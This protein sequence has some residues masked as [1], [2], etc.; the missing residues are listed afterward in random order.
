[1]TQTPLNLKTIH[2]NSS[3]LE[4][5]KKTTTWFLVLQLRH[6]I[7]WLPTLVPEGLEL[8]LPNPSHSVI[9]HS[10]LREKQKQ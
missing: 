1:M 3:L 7:Q 9:C 8:D 4:R 5:K 10:G 2:N 6:Q